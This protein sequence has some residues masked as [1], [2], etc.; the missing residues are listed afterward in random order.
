MI[1]FEQLPS[2]VLT[3]IPEAKEVLAA[4]DNV[5]FA[6]LFGGL[7]SGKP[8]PLSDIDIAVYLQKT[9]NL[10]EYKLDLFHRITNALGT[11][12]LDLIILNTAPVSITGRILQ[13]KQVLVDKNA[14]VRHSFESLNL[15]KFFDFRMKEKIFFSVRYG[16]DR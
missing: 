12:E 6:Y 1:K 15:R 5:V 7:A 2:D 13:Y 8:R 4:D 16:I 11:T 9:D 10:A 14:P 3:R